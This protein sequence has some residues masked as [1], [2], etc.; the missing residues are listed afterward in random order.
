MPPLPPPRKK[1][2][3]ERRRMRQYPPPPP[4]PS[5]SISNCP[6]IF[7]VPFTIVPWGAQ[8][9]TPSL[10]QVS[11]VDDDDAVYVAPKK[12]RADCVEE[13]ACSLLLPWGGGGA[14][15][16]ASV[17]VFFEPQISLLFSSECCPSEATVV[18][19]SDSE[20]DGGAAQ[21]AL[22]EAG[23]TYAPPR[24]FPA[25]YVEPLIPAQIWNF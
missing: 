13:G 25:K 6:P 7:L 24:L 12:P 17:S 9:S 1:S 22:E 19:K 11:I 4:P 23:H 21:R 8:S 14:A 2:G 18:E 10:P 16:S 20:D 15:F 3:H 5:S